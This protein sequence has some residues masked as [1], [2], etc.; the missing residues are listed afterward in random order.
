MSDQITREQ[1]LRDY[2]KKWYVDVMKKRREAWFAANGPCVDCGSWENLELDHDDPSSKVSH[3]VW[4]W[5]E[6]RR[7]EELAKC[8]ARCHR[9]HKKKSV[10]ENFDNGIYGMHKKKIVDG[11]TWCKGHQ[12]FL[13]TENFNKDKHAANGCYSLCKECRKNLPSRI[14][15]KIGAVAHL[16]QSATLRT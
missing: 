13:P 12:D 2:Q 7:I 9:C 15:K 1:Y 10:K 3:A 14:S 4:S 16:D 5:S 6:S 11:K 8:K